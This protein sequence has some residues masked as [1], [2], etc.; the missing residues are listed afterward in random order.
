MRETR[1][2]GGGWIKGSVLLSVVSSVGMLA[3]GVLMMEGSEGSWGA[4]KGSS[5]ELLFCLHESVN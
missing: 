1:G 3:G 4:D 2:G 5:E